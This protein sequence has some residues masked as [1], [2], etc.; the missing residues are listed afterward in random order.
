MKLDKKNTILIGF[1]FLAISAFWQ[2]YDALV[3]LILSGTF[4]IG[5]GHSGF[6][7]AADNVLALFLLPLF[8]ALS[9]RTKT[10]L[11]RR[12]PYILVGTI[13]SV[14]L[15]IAIP[16]IANNHAAAPS[17]TKL[18]VFIVVLGC[19]L[20]AMG[21]WRSPA[22]ALMPDV[23][24]KPLRSKGNAVINLMGAIGGILFLI[25]N[26]VLNSGTN[27]DGHVDFLSVF[28]VVAGIMVVALFVVMLFVNE[29]K[30]AKK[31]ADY[32]AAHPEDDLTEETADGKQKI[33]PA[34]KKSL[35]FMLL[36]VAL[37][38]VGYNAVTTWFTSFARDAWNVSSGS[39][40]LCLTIA[41]AGAI[42]SYIPVGIIASKVG[43]KKTILFGVVLLSF[44]FL[45][46]FA[47]TLFVS[48]FHPALY[49]LFIIIGIAWAAINVNSLPMVI[50]M[51]SGY[52]VG[53][54]TGLYYTFSMSA[55]TITPIISG[56]LYERV[57]SQTLFV[58]AGVAAGLAFVTMLFVK[59]G[60]NK[61]K[62]VKGLEAFDIED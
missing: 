28:A 33:P 8:G 22:V 34:V 9:D 36:S 53:K 4:G 13:V 25:T 15:M 32:E 24:P 43:R 39:A 14:A 5:E 38:Y 7:M 12:K 19:L 10:P 56:Q 40:T 60:D 6:I 52:D 55:Q 26:T 1:A 30:L 2:M 37:W 41:T 16:L 47:Y 17:T 35:I 48:V 27:K 59:H 42:V 58:Y 50:E 45:A 3:P 57:G 49:A 51:C 21:T 18:V 54:F 29:P 11:G 23:T 46:A 20:I 44:G 31:A 61:P 62:A